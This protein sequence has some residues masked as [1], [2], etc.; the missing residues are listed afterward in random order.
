MLCTTLVPIGPK[1]DLVHDDHTPAASLWINPKEHVLAIR[2]HL[3]RQSEVSSSEGKVGPS[4]P[5]AK[6]THG[7]R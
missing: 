2:L 1:R 7:Y 4:M 5:R 3:T 6:I